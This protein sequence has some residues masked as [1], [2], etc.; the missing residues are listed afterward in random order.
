MLEHFLDM[1]GTILETIGT[2][3]EHFASFSWDIFVTFFVF[4]TFL[5][6]IYLYRHLKHFGAGFDWVLILF[7]P[8]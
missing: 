7:G 8:G 5:L 4:L 3:L 2:F 1:F 6:N